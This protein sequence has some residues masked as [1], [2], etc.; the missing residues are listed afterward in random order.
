MGVESF[1]NPLISST[2]PLG[3][4]VLSYLR[5]KTLVH[6]SLSISLIFLRS[7][8]PLHLLL[9]SINYTAK[10]KYQLIALP[11]LAATVAAQDLYVVFPNAINDNHQLTQS[12]QLHPRRAPDCPPQLSRR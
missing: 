1:F 7:L 4:L 8:S 2:S 11:A 12:Q 5:T 6:L 10:M 3:F 9:H